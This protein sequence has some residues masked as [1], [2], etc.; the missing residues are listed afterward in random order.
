MAESDVISESLSRAAWPL[1]GRMK[2]P[3][4]KG[5]RERKKERVE[6]FPFTAPPPLLRQAPSTMSWYLVISPPEPDVLL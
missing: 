6:T 4:T 2:S 5:E 3:T 1:G